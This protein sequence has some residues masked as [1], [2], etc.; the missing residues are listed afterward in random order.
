M[1]DTPGLKPASAPRHPWLACVLALAA[2]AHAQSPSVPSPLEDPRI[3]VGGENPVYGKRRVFVSYDW[4]DL[5]EGETLQRVRLRMLHPFGEELRYAWQIELPYED[6]RGEGGGIARGLSDIG[7]RLNWTF[8]RTP[9]LR[10]NANLNI[11]WETGQDDRLGDNATLLQPQYA[12]SYARSDTLVLNGR[13]TYTRSIDRD[14]G[15]PVINR[16]TFEPSVTF[17]LP[18]QWSC[19]IATRLGWSFERDKLAATVRG[20]LGFILGERNQW[21]FDAFV[22]QSLTDFAR[23]TQFERA[24]GVD[25]VRYF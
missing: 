6:L 19:A 16:L 1:R 12:F 3:D 13:L 5:R 17:L 22:E 20:T 15:A 9:R 8:Y 14:R 10:Q 4:Q 7:T 2:F 24:V 23:R 11:Q 21:E 18:E 25:L